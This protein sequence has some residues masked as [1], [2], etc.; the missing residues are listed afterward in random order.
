LWAV[1]HR[2]GEVDGKNDKPAA[3]LMA[4]FAVQVVPV[5]S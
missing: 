1:A 4:K 5:R 3:G 2:I